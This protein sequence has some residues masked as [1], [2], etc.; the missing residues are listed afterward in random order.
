MNIPSFHPNL[1]QIIPKLLQISIKRVKNAIISKKK[2][3]YV[4]T[5]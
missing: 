4:Y 3:E 2:I 1:Y 5:Y